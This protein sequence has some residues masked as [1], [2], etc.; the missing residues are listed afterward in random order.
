MKTKDQVKLL[1][2]LYELES[3]GNGTDNTRTFRRIEKSLDPALLKRYH[4]LKERKGTG[5][6][7]LK[8]S[9]CS[10]CKMVYPESHEILRYKNFI[11]HCEY[12]GRL[13]VVTDKSV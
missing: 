10:G 3:N 11:H 12:C 9:V 7:V 5:V 2:K 6:A 8:D 4:K 1:L 13:L